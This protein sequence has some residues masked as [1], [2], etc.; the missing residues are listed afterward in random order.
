M[1]SYVEYL[2]TSQP[3]IWQSLQNAAA[4]GLV[5]IDEEKDAVTASNRLLLTYPDLH[6]VLEMMTQNWISTTA[7]DE[8]TNMITS[9][10]EKK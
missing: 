6:E 10:L 5:F 7:L 1:G 9:L 4:E 2:K 3:A 8:G